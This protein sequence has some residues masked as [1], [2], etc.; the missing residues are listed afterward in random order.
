M[1]FTPAAGWVSIETAARHDEYVKTIT[2]I[3]A[4]IQSGFSANV[5]DAFSRS[6]VDNAKALVLG[7]TIAKHVAELN[8]ERISV[9]GPGE[10]QGSV[11]AVNLP[12]TVSDLESPA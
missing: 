4:G 10:D 8:S 1:K 3:G 12:R 11:F 6:G 2:D 5:F 7:S 9:A